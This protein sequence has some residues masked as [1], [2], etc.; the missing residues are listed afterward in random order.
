MLERA[1][2]YFKAKKFLGNNYRWGGQY[3]A[4]S[5]HRWSPTSAPYFKPLGPPPSFSV[6]KRWKTTL[7]KWILNFKHDRG[8]ITITSCLFKKRIVP[9][10]INDIS[11]LLPNYFS[12]KKRFT[13]IRSIGPVGAIS[14]QNQPNC[15]LRGIFRLQIGRDYQHQDCVPLT[16]QHSVLWSASVSER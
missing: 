9:K 14:K 7:Q 3:L 8:T 12:S 1:G 6:N 16:K 11:D 13:F 10:P 4:R 5:I 15:F 2:V